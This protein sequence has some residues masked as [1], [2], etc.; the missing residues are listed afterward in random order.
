MA[1]ADVWIDAAEVSDLNVGKTEG[2]SGR[3]G[4]FV[5]VERPLVRERGIAGSGDDE[6]GGAAG[7]QRRGQERHRAAD[8]HRVRVDGRAEVRVLDRDVKR[9]LPGRRR[10]ADK[11][12]RREAQTRRDRPPNPGHN[13]DNIRHPAD[14]CSHILNKT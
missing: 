11:L 9:V 10:G 6:R 5:A 14:C 7:E 1:A 3:A 8:D 4:D 12:A 13:S 2:G